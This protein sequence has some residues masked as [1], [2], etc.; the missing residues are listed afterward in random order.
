[1][2]VKASAVVY[3]LSGSLTLPVVVLLPADYNEEDKNTKIID[4]VRD[5]RGVESDLAY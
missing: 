1:M 2:K 4:N 3:D 5:I